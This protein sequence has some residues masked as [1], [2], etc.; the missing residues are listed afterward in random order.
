MKEYK[1][2]KRIDG[3]LLEFEVTRIAS[4]TGQDMY[5]LSLSLDKSF[6]HRVVPKKSAYRAIKFACLCL[7]TLEAKAIECGSVLIVSLWLETKT[8]MYQK[9]RSSFFSEREGW[10]PVVNDSSNH[11]TAYLFNDK[12]K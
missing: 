12:R 9:R 5:D 6:S 7:S 10:I 11:P 8:D 3:L 2:K 4:V 1:I